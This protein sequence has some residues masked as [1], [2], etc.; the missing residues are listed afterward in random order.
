[1]E[2]H[3]WSSNKQRRRQ[4]QSRDAERANSC[5]VEFVVLGIRVIWSKTFVFCDASMS[6]GMIRIGRPP[7][8]TTQGYARRANTFWHMVLL[9]QR[10]CYN[11]ELVPYAIAV[12]SS[13]LPVGTTLPKALSI[14]CCGTWIPWCTELWCA[15]CSKWHSDFLLEW[16]EVFWPVWNIE[17][18]AAFMDGLQRDASFYCNRK[19]IKSIYHVD[20]GFV[21]LCVYLCCIH[22]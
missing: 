2:T 18:S 6:V 21:V 1:M 16:W 8:C 15:P 20:V 13:Q 22:I 17:R 19:K 7:A 11:L 10:T 5:W 3:L 4:S 14:M 12:K 9:R